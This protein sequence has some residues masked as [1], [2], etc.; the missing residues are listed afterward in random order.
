M[1]SIPKL[2]ET[3]WRDGGLLRPLPWLG[4]FDA[5]IRALEEVCGKNDL[6]AVSAILLGAD[7]IMLVPR[8]HFTRAMMGTLIATLEKLSLPPPSPGVIMHVYGTL[9]YSLNLPFWRDDMA[10]KSRTKWLRSLEH[11]KLPTKMPPKWVRD[12]RTII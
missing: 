10:P 5:C 11:A 3:F 2:R 7:D 4:E 6:M 9:Q 1:E 8:K 12:T